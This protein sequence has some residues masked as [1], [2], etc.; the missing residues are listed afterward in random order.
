MEI[1]VHT[2]ESWVATHPF[3]QLIADLQGAVDDVTETQ[4]SSAASAEWND[5]LPEF[6]LGVPALCSA[7]I[8]VDF[9]PV[10]KSL[11]A[12][13]RALAVNKR[14]PQPITGQIRQLNAELDR[15]GDWPSRVV[16]GLLDRE[17]PATAA[18][19]LVRYIG[20]TVLR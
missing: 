15:D 5:Y 2:R 8:S 17:S 3:L 7:S 16:D 12:V 4:V 10:Q 9:R 20:W 14:L 18:P 1:D 19:G 11:A 13:V 6:K